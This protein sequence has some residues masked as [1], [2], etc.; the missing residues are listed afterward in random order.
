[1]I[2]IKPSFDG[3]MPTGNAVAAMNLIRLGRLTAR[4]D[5]EDLGSRIF[6]AFAEEMRNNPA[7]LTHMISALGMARSGT[8]EV[9]IAGDPCGDDTRRLILALQRS[10]LPAVTAWLV[11]PENP[12][13]SLSDLAP[14][15][16]H[17]NTADGKAAAYICRNFSC[18]PSVTDPGEMLTALSGKQDPRP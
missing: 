17:M 6:Q 1:M 3:P 16:S 18:L 8:A 5:I 2:S 4:Q 11:D 13:P 10:F 14:Y 15:A 9:I 12:D 7:G